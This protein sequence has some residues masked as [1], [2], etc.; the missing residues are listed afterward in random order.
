MALTDAAEASALVS[1][2][3]VKRLRGCH[4]ASYKRWAV[5]GKMTV[6]SDLC[7]RDKT[8]RLN[9]CA[10][11]SDGERERSEREDASDLA[12]VFYTLLEIHHL[13]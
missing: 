9:V 11:K 6:V 13:C 12:T 5:E 8:V 7:E 2:C 1:M 10:E 4:L 3:F